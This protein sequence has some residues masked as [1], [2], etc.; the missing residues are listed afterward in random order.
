MDNQT[1]NLVNV[2]LLESTFTR[3]WVIDFNNKDFKTNLELDLGNTTNEGHL[4]VTVGIKYVAGIGDKHNI[5][6]SIKMV[7]IFTKP[8]ASELPL[9]TFANINAPAIIFPFI[10]EHLASLSMKALINPILL[11][12]VN[13]VKNAAE[14]KITSENK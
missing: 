10:R 11:Q 12:P 7:G 3:D 14:A 1:F 6:S 4:M 2:I 8:S 5:N 9:E 13:F